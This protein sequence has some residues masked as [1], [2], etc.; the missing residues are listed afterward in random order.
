MDTRIY[1]GPFLLFMLV[2][3]SFFF[4]VLWAQ[5]ILLIISIFLIHTFIIKLS[6]DILLEYVSF[7]SLGIQFAYYAHNELASTLLKNSVFCRKFPVFSLKIS[8]FSSVCLYI[9]QY[10]FMFTNSKCV[11]LSLIQF[12]FISIC[13]LIIT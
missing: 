6:H 9:F 13:Y 5:S 12:I 10:H 8:L 2:I 11:R 1:F 7:K 3:T 4:V